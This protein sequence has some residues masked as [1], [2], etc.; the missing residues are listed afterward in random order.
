M[1]TFDWLTAQAKRQPDRL[2]MVDVTTKRRVTYAQLDARACRVAELVSDEWGIAPGERIAVLAHNGIEYFELLYGCAKAGVLMVCLNWRLAPRELLEILRDCTPSAL[3]YS[4]AFAEHAPALCAEVGVRHRVS[5]ENGY[6]TALAAT[7]GA[8]VEMPAT[9]LETPWHLLYT[10]GTTGKPKGVIQTFSM[11]FYNAVHTMLST[12]LCESDTTLNVLP[13]FHTGG[14]NLYANPTLHVGGTVLLMQTV[15]PA[16]ILALLAGQV[17]NVPRPSLFFGVPAIY[18]ELLRQPGFYDADLTHVRH[19]GCGGAPA[20]AVLQD[21]WAARG[22]PLRNGF[23]MTETGPTVFV[24]QAGDPA[25]ARR[26]VGRPCLHVRAKVVDE[27]GAECPADTP[28]RLLV[29]GPGIT[30]GYWNNDNAT[31]AALVDGWLHTG[32]VASTDERGY[33]TIVGRTKDMYISG[34]ENVY[35]AEVEDVIAAMTGVLE[36][37]VIGVPD[38][39]W[40]EVGAACVVLEP[41]ATLTSRQ[42]R[43]HCRARL[44]GY[45]V[46]K[47][48]AMV[49]ALPRNASGKVLKHGL[50]ALLPC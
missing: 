15:D 13:C 29:K 40:G 8:E 9:P 20:P 21:A 45:K 5:I 3:V 14:L 31:T 28:G 37:G 25:D 30:P 43:A 33:V 36:V 10:S 35:P 11:V 2:A 46:P 44:A 17:P 1:Y 26:T 6:E 4:E 32:D 7:A 42:I 23:G 27:T 18:Q 34:G 24:S 49:E 48:V 50:S 22:T 16:K 19:L 12:D 41:T 38:A 39:R 47:H